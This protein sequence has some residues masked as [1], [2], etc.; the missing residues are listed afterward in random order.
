VPQNRKTYNG[1][2]RQKGILGRRHGV[3][4]VRVVGLAGQQR[5]LGLVVVVHLLER[6]G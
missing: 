2:E 5:P 4:R 1:Q 3:V 6:H